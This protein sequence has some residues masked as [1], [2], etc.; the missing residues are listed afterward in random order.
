[1]ARGCCALP[2][3]F[4]PILE[5]QA[6]VSHRLQP[7][8]R[9]NRR[10]DGDGAHDSYAGRGG[11]PVRFCGRRPRDP[12]LHRDRRA[13]RRGRGRV[14]VL[15]A[16]LRGHPRPRRERGHRPARAGHH[17]RPCLRV[18][19]AWSSCTR[20]G[21]GSRCPGWHA[22]CSRSA[23]SPRWPPTWP[24]AGPTGQSARWSQPGPPPVSS[25]V[26]SCSS[27]SSVPLH[28]A[29]RFAYQTRTT[30]TRRRTTPSLVHGSLLRRV[31]AG[32][33]T[34][35]ES[36]FVSCPAAGMARPS[37]T[38]LRKRTRQADRTSYN[39]GRAA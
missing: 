23:S 28:Q 29:A 25:G 39:G 30:P 36:A 16:R 6:Y 27:G 4:S 37:W 21:T 19:D 22:G 2:G 12:H 10:E 33:A 14:R 11:V 31:P 13:R 32:W 1:M 34:A 18:L 15:L 8:R 9:G 7:P 24:R 5:E 26:T 17:R 38:A 20:R 3:S 35:T